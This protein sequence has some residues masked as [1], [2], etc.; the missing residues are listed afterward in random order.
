MLILSSSVNVP[1]PCG[2]M[3][4]ADYLYAFQKLIMPIA[5]EFSPDLVIGMGPNHPMF[6]VLF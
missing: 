5:F 3:R 4:D 1:W 6:L 2:G